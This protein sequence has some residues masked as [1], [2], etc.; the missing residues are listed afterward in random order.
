MPPFNGSG[1]FSPTSADN[2]VV[3]NTLIESTKFNNTITDIASGLSTAITK[4]GQTTVTANI[5]LNNN[6]ITGLAAGTA[7]TDAASLATIQD[8][9]GIYVATVGGTADVITLTPSPAITAYAAGQAFY[10]IASGANTTNVTVAI[11]GLAAKAI[12]KNG[13]TAL[14]A[15]DIPSG[16]LIGA[17]YDGTRFQLMTMGNAT[18]AAPFID[19]TALVKG[20]ADATKLVRVEA[21]GLTT[22]TT[23]VWTAPDKDLKVAGIVDLRSYLSGC[24]MSTAGSSATMSIAAGTA[25]DSTN[26][27]GMQLAAIAKTTSAWAVGTAQGGLDTGSIANSTW[28]HFYVIQRTDTGVVD[29]VFST[30]AT[31]PTM[32]TNYTLFRRIG[33]GLTNGSAQWVNFTQN[34]DDFNWLSPVLDVNALATSATAALAT[35]S[36]PLGVKVKAYFNAIISGTIGNNTSYF[37]DPAVTDQAASTTAAPLSSMSGNASQ[38]TCYTNTSSQ[39]RHRENNTTGNL[40]IA[41]LGW[42]DSRGRNA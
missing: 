28:Y 16:A 4:D 6:K 25:V 42:T 1:V 14:V 40:Y 35:L 15:G 24:A 23:R 34:G 36:V 33:S 39:I 38:N 41:T 19:S 5:P 22:A 12:T 30:N 20:S 37:S 2:P 27:S 21:D 10:W 7:R 3:P 17:R 18:Y 29:V 8:G 31:S 13:S 9:T 32:P 26:V 11:S